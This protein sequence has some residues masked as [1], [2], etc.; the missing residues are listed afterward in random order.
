M[1]LLLDILLLFGAI[2]AKCIIFGLI[3]LYMDN[4]NSYIGNKIMPVNLIFI[5]LFT[6]WLVIYF[7][8][9]SLIF[10]FIS[11]TTTYQRLNI[12]SREVIKEGDKQEEYLI[13]HSTFDLFSGYVEYAVTYSNGMLSKVIRPNDIPRIKRKYDLY[14]ILKTK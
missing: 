11:Y 13:T 4:N 5:V 10:F 9:G 7:L 2:L 1:G 12:K 14:N 3:L 6:E 8:I